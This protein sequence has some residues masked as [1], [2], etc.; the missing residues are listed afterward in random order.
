MIDFSRTPMFQRFEADR[1]HSYAITDELLEMEGITVVPGSDFGIP[2]T[3][4]ISL[5]IEEV[6]F[7]E[8]ITKIV[9]YLNKV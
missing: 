3:A 5:V 2:N 7:G 4:R 6:P 9:R 1:D 8:A